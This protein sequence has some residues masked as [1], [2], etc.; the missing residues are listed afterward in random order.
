MLE[1]KVKKALEGFDLDV[2]FSVN[3]EILS[4]MGPSGSGKT[5]TL[6]CIA[7]LVK[8]DEGY[9]KLNGRVLFDSEHGL[10]LPA[11]VRR[12]G[13]VF[14][15]YALFSHLTVA[16]NIAYGIKNLPQRVVRERVA[17]L[18]ELMHLPGLEHRYPREI[19]SGQQQRVAMARALAPEPE[20]LLLDE[21]FSA[22]DTPRRERLEYEILQLQKFYEG[23]ILFVTH[24]L[25]E[26]YKLGS[27][28]AIYENGRIVQCDRKN[29]VISAPVNPTAARLAGVKNLM[30]GYVKSV[31]DSRVEVFIPKL[32]TTLKVINKQNLSLTENQEVIIG[33]RPEHINM[34]TGGRDNIIPCQVNEIIEGVIDIHCHLYSSAD[35]ARKYTIEMISPRSSSPD[36]CEG[37]TYDFYLPPEHLIIVPASQDNSP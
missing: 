32:G 3:K 7:G 11:R 13:F 23:D 1:V 18:I 29:N 25:A 2:D 12:I 24:D 27:R 36:I 20:A 33:I 16:E 34:A 35:E 19:S 26:G 22:L 28:I 5:M 4:I 37:H 9:I 6:R 30:Q 15:N 31:S 17:Q 14:Q 10:C 8:P 21:P